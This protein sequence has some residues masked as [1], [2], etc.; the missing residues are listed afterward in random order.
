MNKLIECPDAQLYDSGGF[1]DIYQ[2]VLGGE[3]VALKQLKVF[4]LAENSKA[5]SALEVF[6]ECALGGTS[7]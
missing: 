7:L 2:G 1:C 4:K 6:H 5:E 3:K